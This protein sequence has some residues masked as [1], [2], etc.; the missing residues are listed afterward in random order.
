MRLKVCG[1]A[2]DVRWLRGVI[3]GVSG[4]Q[5]KCASRQEVQRMRRRR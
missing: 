2:R 3:R 1:R 4:K 5:G